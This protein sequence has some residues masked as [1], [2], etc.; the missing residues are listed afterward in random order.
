MAKSKIIEAN[1]KMAKTVTEAFSKIEQGFVEGYSKIEDAFVD[2]YLTKDGETV[3]EAKERLKRE[4][5]DLK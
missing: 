2:R 4:S 3:G 5:N 1:K